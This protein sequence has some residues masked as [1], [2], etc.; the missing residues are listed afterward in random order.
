MLRCQKF[1][2]KSEFGC[3]LA[4]RATSSGLSFRRWSHFGVTWAPGLHLG[5]SVLPVP[6][7]SA[8]IHSCETVMILSCTP[9]DFVGALSMASLSDWEGVIYDRVGVF[10]SWFGKMMPVTQPSPGHGVIMAC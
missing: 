3:L 8:L 4:A 1:R 5:L 2:H 10:N 6:G 7:S 9:R